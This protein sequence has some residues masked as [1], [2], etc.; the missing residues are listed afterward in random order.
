MKKLAPSLAGLTLLA[1]LASGQ[2]YLLPSWG[3]EATDLFTEYTSF[4]AFDLYDSLLYATDGD[5]IHCLKLASGEPVRKYGKPASYDSYASF[6][7]I[8]PGGKELWAG[9]TVIGNVDDRI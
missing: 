5:T 3:Y 6:L 2:S 8:S 1:C 7:S 9:F 4:Q